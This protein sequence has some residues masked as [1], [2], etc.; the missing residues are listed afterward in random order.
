MEKPPISEAL[1]NLDL[2]GM[3]IRTPGLSIKKEKCRAQTERD[4]A[5]YSF[6]FGLGNW[7][8]GT[9]TLPGLYQV[10]GAQNYLAGLQPFQVAQQRYAIMHCESLLLSC[11]GFNDKSFEFSHLTVT[12]LPYV[13]V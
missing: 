12:E 3:G 6:N 5:I 11:L 2:H 4:S 13:A 8:F 7:A 9:T 10:S 1:Y